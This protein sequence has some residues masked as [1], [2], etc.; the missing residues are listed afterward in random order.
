MTYRTSDQANPFS[1]SSLVP[2]LI[3]GLILTLAGMLVAFVL[4]GRTAAK[5]QWALRRPLRKGAFRRR[6]RPGFA[7][8]RYTAI[9]PARRS[10]PPARRP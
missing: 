4:S 7:A 3:A 6:A 8:G 10:Q 9:R 2:M 1:G 5:C